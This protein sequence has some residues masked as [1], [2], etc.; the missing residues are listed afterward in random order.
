MA[1]LTGLAV[2]PGCRLS[3]LSSPPPGL[4]S[5][6]RLEPLEPHCNANPNTSPGSEQDTGPDFS[7]MK[8]DATPFRVEW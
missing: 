3:H 2:D 4:L 7:S 1:S 6:S 8:V 5:S